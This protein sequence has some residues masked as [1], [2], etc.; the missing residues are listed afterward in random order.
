M[1]YSGRIHDPC[2]DKYIKSTKD[3]RFLFAF[4]LA[5][6][7]VYGF[8]L[9]GENS[10]EMDNPEALYIGLVIGAMFMAIGI[11]VSFFGKADATWDGI[12][13]YK[14]IL[15]KK[16][17]TLYMVYIEDSKKIRHEIESENDATL[18]NY[19]KVGEKVRYHGKLKSY[20]KFDKSGDDIIFCNACSFLNS[21]EA[22][23]CEN[24]GCLLLK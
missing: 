7:A 2:F 8:Y 15:E 1:A 14:A 19:Y 6:V 16:D 21:I 24:C 13:I 4:L 10:S 23:A 12:V 11:Y 18:Y 3:Y 22:D 17:K 9:Y 20:E 5:F